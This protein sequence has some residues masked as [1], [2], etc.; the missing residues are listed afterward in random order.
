[1]QRDRFAGLQGFIGLAS[2]ALVLLSALA[3][4][5]NRPVSWS[6]LSVFVTAL[7][8]LQLLI[9]FINPVPLQIKRAAGPAVCVGIAILWATL[10]VTPGLPAALAH[11]VWEFVPDAP[12][13]ISADPGKGRH[14]VMRMCLYAMVFV[15]LLRAATQVERAT[16]AMRLIAVFST[17]LALF[18]LYAFATGTN[19]LL[20]DTASGAVVQ[21]GFVNR[22]SYATYA[23]FGALA[24]IA[25]YLEI[26]DRRD[27]N[28]RGRLE[29]FFAG[30]WVFA[31]GAL[32]CAGALSLTQSRAGAGAGL[33]GL[34]VFL[35]AW[36]SGRG[37]RDRVMLAVIGVTLVFIAATSATGLLKRLI[38]TDATDGRFQIYPAVREA[39]MDRPLLGHGAG[40]FQDA[41]RSYVPPAGA[42]GEWDMAHSTWLELAFGLGLPVAGVFI[43]AQ[44]L[45]VIRLWR[46]ARKRRENRVFACLALGCASA[47][48]FHSIFDFSLQMPAIAALYAAI[49]GIGF[50][51]SFTFRELEKNRSADR[52]PQAG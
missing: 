15:M 29:R 1:M 33:I 41:F 23:V 34:L 12:S 42:V 52:R 40:A 44:V 25:C 48:G 21:A 45:I 32:I 36:R 30:A 10:Q 7:F 8:T 3:L 38:A 26:A 50:A 4:G 11:P 20:G 14:A 16:K 39:I 35:L 6:L 27:D 17:V 24:N 22:N 49:L 46:G 19:L 2:L 43:L 13:F 31:L 18:G 9:S 37:G 28:L 5:A 51:Q 47:A